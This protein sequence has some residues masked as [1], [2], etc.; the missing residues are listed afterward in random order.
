MADPSR[1][2]I[3]DYGGACVSNLV[4]AL[5]QHAEIGRGWVPDEVL[6]AHQV[7]L[8][9]ID[10]LGWDQLQERADLAPT[11]AAMTT[12]SITTVAPT[13]TATALTFDRHGC[14][15]R[16]A[17]CGRLQDPRR[18]RVAEHAALVERGG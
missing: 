16:G 5:L 1:P 6:D 18:R 7:V 10:G 12:R 17:R 14:A 13:T 15:S 9:V 3:P 4:P 11:L 2:L 8:F